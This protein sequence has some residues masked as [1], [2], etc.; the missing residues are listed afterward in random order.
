MPVRFGH[1][2]SNARKVARINKF[3]K[4]NLFGYNG[5]V[6]DKEL[7]LSIKVEETALLFVFYCVEGERWG[8]ISKTV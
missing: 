7:M 5:S 8:A 2:V 6:G 3:R 4:V 1:A